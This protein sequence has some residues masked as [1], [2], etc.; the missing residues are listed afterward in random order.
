MLFIPEL[1][2]KEEKGGCGKVHV[3]D[4]NGKYARCPCIEFQ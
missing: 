2:I 1:V 3:S 4:S